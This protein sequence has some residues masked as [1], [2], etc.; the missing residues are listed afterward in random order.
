MTQA[1]R[2]QDVAF[3][4][5][6][7]AMIVLPWYRIEGGFYSFGW[8]SSYPNDLAIA[9]AAL[10]IFEFG[11]WWLLVAAVPL[12]VAGASRFIGAPERQGLVLA[13]AG[14]I[15]VAYLIF[16]GLA[17]NF[18]GW[19]WSVSETLFGPMSDGQ[20][21]MGAGAIVT[22]IVFVLLFRSALRNAV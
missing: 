8:L 9:P 10:E 21:S 20:P 2:R 22:A 19:S 13:W 14:A 4:V 12:L 17:I 18:S 3:I 7:L 6:L 16:Q 5:G 15:G 11:R 1:S